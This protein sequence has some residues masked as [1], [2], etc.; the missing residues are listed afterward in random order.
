M[1]QDPPSDPWF[2]RGALCAV[3][4]LGVVML[5]LGLEH[6]GMFKWEWVG[7]TYLATVSVLAWA[8][9]GMMWRG[10]WVSGDGPRFVAGC[11]TLVVLAYHAI[12]VQGPG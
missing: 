1:D 6:S 4:C 8:G 10:A 7:W 5:A 2:R 9:V 11:W 3:A 12:L